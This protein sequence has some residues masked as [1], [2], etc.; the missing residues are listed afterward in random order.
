MTPPPGCVT[1]SFVAEP[2]QRLGRI[3]AEK[4]AKVRQE[5]L[6]KAVLAS[7]A[8]P[9]DSGSE[10]SEQLV[11]GFVTALDRSYEYCR[12][13]GPRT[14]LA[15][16]FNGGKDACVVLYLWLASAVAAA[17]STGDQDADGA[18]PGQTV[19][20]FDSTD[21]FPAV[22]SFVKFVIKS[23]GLR[24]LV[25]EGSN[26]KQGMDTLVASGLRAVVMGQR[27]GDPWM[28]GVD[29]FSPSTPGWPAFLRI[30]PVIDWSFMHVWMFLRVFGLPYCALY[31]EGFTSLGSLNDTA[32]N[33]QLLRS[34]GSYRPA[35]ELLDETSERAGRLS[36]R[37][38]K[39][40]T[41]EN[42][43]IKLI[44]E[45]TDPSDVIDALHEGEGGTGHTVAC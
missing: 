14:D 7:G 26:F 20:Y 44:P 5:R 39:D 43:D 9:F 36:K 18:I 25:I 27:R 12:M 21:E 15:V 10:D 45:N 17:A 42:Q 2:I 6:A 31:D 1:G 19:I 30:N 22:R 32:R 4:D 24:M 38:A 29:V 16:S 33:P 23:L 37:R 3:F 35:Y 11:S 41:A 34:D 40:Q 13:A 8:Y 28:D